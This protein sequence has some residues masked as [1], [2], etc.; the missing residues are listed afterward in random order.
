MVLNHRLE[1]HSKA[2]EERGKELKTE[3]GGKGQK[4]EE[5]GD[6][7]GEGRKE[8]WREGLKEG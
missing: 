7:E 4:T 1:T 8:G 2:A 3:D 6:Q 5:E